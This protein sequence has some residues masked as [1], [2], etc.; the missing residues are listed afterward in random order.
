MTDNVA[1]QKK[2]VI[3][4]VCGHANRPGALVCENCGSL[5]DLRAESRR[6]TRD[7]RDAQEKAT[8]IDDGAI[9]EEFAERVRGN[10]YHEGLVVQLKVDDFG[11]QPVMVSPS[12]LKGEVVLGRRDPITEQVPE[13]DLDQFAGYRMG[14]SRRHAIMHF[15]NGSLTITDMGSSNGTFVNGQRLEARKPELIR[16][17][18]LLRLGQI[19]MTVKFVDVSKGVSS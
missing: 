10:T 7:L 18:D 8:E 15:R 13:V 17:G 3:C 14:V 1:S 19:I 16:D 4:P 12:M 5:L 11:N 9:Q 2:Q 6:A